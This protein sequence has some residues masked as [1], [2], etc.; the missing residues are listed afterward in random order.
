MNPEAVRLFFGCSISFLLGG[1]AG[2]FGVRTLY[3]QVDQV[4]PETPTSLVCP[5]PPPCPA[6]PPPVDCGAVGG[7]L[8]SDPPPTPVERPPLDR[9]ADALPGLPASV[10]PLAH[11][12]VKT[13]IAPCLDEVPASASGVALLA[14][15]VTATGGEG[16]LRDAVVTRATGDG[17][18]VA[19]C[20]ARSARSARF[21]WSGPDG[22]LTFKIPIS[23]GSSTR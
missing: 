13:A 15:T 6:C 12:A 8:P 16:F 9:P 4:A 14:L 3:G 19:D 2:V 11:A 23:V 5:P 17:R 10:L 7:G 1:A 18:D 22:Q 20:L 21:R